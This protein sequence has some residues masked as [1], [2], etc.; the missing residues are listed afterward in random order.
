MQ[1]DDRISDRKIKQERL[2]NAALQ[3]LVPRRIAAVSAREIPPYSSVGSTPKTNTNWTQIYQDAQQA[4]QTRPKCRYPTLT[5]YEQPTADNS[6]SK[7]NDTKKN[8]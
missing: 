4:E 7:S 8:P 5:I 6:T 1:I 3:V 2:E